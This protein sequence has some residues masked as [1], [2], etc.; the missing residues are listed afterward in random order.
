M[1]DRQVEAGSQY[2]MEI[3]VEKKLGKDNRQRAIPIAN[4]DTSAA[5]GECG[6][7]QPPGQPDN[8]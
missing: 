3:N 2:G 5:T 8:R 1:T 6:I 7:M 4:Y